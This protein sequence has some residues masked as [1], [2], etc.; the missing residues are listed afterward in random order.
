MEFTFN[1]SALGAG[2]IIQR[3]DVTTV[4][5]S[6]GSLALAPTGGEGRTIEKNYWSEELAF[7]HA[8][9]RV[10]GREQP[11]GGVFTTFTYV[12]IKDLAIF[13][14]KLTIA[15]MRATVTS[16]H[17]FRDEDDND[18]E[19][20]VQYKGVRV[21][22]KEI[23]PKIDVAIASVRRYQHLEQILGESPA[24][25]L[26]QG[27]KSSNDK[28]ALAERFNA[29]SPEVLSR[30]LKERKAVQGT[31]IEK[32][33]G[34]V[35]PRRH[36]KIF[37]P[38]LGTVRFAELMIKPGRRRLNL[39]RIALGDRDETAAAF[40]QE[41]AEPMMAMIMAESAESSLR[42]SMTVASVEGNGT[43]VGP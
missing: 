12:L 9:T 23:E 34:R 38:G 22:G 21:E 19:V 2:G 27:L 29:A 32:V 36:H 37:I 4:I 5:P 26:S 31:M 20:T 42:G 10:Y 11:G 3:G 16:T 25:K 33:E 39:L 28:K 18:L 14:D 8:E 24:V 30:R 17:D 35:Q 1:A 43:L 13:G 40:N 7:S 6:L 41:T 15:E